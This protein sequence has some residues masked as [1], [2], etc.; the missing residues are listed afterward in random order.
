M[1]VGGAN[2]KAK[3]L[4]PN[5]VDFGCCTLSCCF[6]KLVLFL[7]GANDSNKANGDILS[8]STDTLLIPSNWALFNVVTWKY[9]I[10]KDT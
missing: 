5:A 9:K 2:F 6:A 1:N 10:E 8:C 7:T 4:L 3:S